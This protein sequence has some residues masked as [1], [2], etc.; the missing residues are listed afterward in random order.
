MARDPGQ[1]RSPSGSTAAAFSAGRLSEAPREPP[2]EAA[3]GS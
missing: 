1:I 3:F 2:E